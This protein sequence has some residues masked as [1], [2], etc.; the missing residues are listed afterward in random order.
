MK[1]SKF[2]KFKIYWPYFIF[3]SFIVVLI[4][5]FTYIIIANKTWRGLWTEN[6]YQKGLNHNDAL[7]KAENQ[8]KLGVKIL[9]NVIKNSDN[10]FF[11]ETFVKDRN[12]NFITNLAIL[13]RLKYLPDSKYDFTLDSKF[14]SSISRYANLTLEK[15]GYW[16][17][18][19]IVSNQAFVAQDIIDLKVTLKSDVDNNKRK[20]E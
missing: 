2:S 9:T 16:Q 6:S 15:N 13:Y 5:N 19:T 14:A 10:K 20:Y 12:N 7:K 17:I 3:G 11:I 4:V 8:K 18:E 1:F